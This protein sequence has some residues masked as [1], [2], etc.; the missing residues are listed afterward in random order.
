MGFLLDL[1]INAAVLFW[2]ARILPAVRV[3]NYGTA[4]LVAL[5]V[6]FLNATVGFLLRFPLNLVTLFLLEFLVRLLVTALMIKV[7][8]ALISGF[9][10]RGFR[11]ALL[12]ALV[13]A[14]LGSVV[15]WVF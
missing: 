5:L 10:V 2:L 1:L 11:T 3:R 13:M 15:Q 4:V 9:A 8:G 12:M 6:A 14:V 7:A